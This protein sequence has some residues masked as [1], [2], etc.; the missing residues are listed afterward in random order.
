MQP[1]TL[2]FRDIFRRFGR[3]SVLR[4]VSG[5]V[6]EG[7]ILLITGSNGSGKSTLLKCLAG[8]LSPDRGTITYS[9]GVYAPAGTTSPA[10]D[11]EQSPVTEPARATVHNA[12]ASSEMDS[13]RRRL[14]YLAPDLALYD[15]LTVAENLHFFGRLRRRSA[16]TA[17]DRAVALGLPPNRAAGALSSGMR[18][19]LRLCWATLHEPSILL[20]DEP[21][22]NLDAAGRQA[23]WDLLADHLSAGGG[24]VLASPT[25]LRLP[26][27]LESHVHQHLDLS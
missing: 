14:G 24:L 9:E 15:E 11:P 4:G 7:Q 5:D 2:S 26:T 10:Q 3:V 1:A 20:F 12:P 16:A 21:F 8:L 25:D 19:R 23:F 22:Q 27:A 13:R 18:Q 17:I 6:R